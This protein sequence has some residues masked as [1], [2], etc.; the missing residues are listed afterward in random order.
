MVWDIY[1]TDYCLIHGY[2]SKF[3]VL[4]W[5]HCLWL[6]QEY[7]HWSGT[8]LYNN[9]SDYCRFDAIWKVIE[10]DWNRDD[11]GVTVEED[12][13]SLVR[14]TSLAKPSNPAMR[15]HT[16]LWWFLPEKDA[17]FDEHAEWPGDMFGCRW[18][19]IKQSRGYHIFTRQSHPTCQHL[20]AIGSCW[21]LDELNCSVCGSQRFKRSTK[22]HQDT[23]RTSTTTPCRYLCRAQRS[24]RGDISKIWWVLIVT[25]AWYKNCCAVF[26]HDIKGKIVQDGICALQKR[27]VASTTSWLFVGTCCEFV[28]SWRSFSI[29]FQLIW[30]SRPWRA[31]RSHST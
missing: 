18:T 21:P 15:I 6:S 25:I 22:L 8:Y 26:F 3:K 28:W 1:K 12:T 23:C 30:R 24:G 11:P 14:A 5:D 10:R 9:I 19:R 7:L 31:R 20:Y 29:F 27:N 13:P 4:I 2:S 17:F 16:A